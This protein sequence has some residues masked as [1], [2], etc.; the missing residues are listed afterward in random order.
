M[1]MIAVIKH[2]LLSTMFLFVVIMDI[3]IYNVLEDIS[4]TGIE[5][6]LINSLI[7]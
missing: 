2:C 1:I 4:D 3:Q 7:I 5:N 6:M